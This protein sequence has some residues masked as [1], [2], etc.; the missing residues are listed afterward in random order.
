MTLGMSDTDLHG[1]ELFGHPCIPLRHLGI[2]EKQESK[3]GKSE[4]QGRPTE[5]KD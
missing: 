2:S 5:E 3:S 1:A 4:K